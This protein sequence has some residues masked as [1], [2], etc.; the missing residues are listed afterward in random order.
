MLSARPDRPR[1]K[2]SESHDAANPG[3]VVNH[4]NV[5]ARQISWT[6]VT[7]DNPATRARVPGEIM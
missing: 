2:S 6:S 3:R 7:P 1:A 5:A 4:E